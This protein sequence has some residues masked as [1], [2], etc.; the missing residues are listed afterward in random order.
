VAGNARLA[1]EDWAETA[2]H[3]FDVLEVV[4]TVQE[5]VQLFGREAGQRI[6]ELGED[7]GNV[8]T[9][10]TRVPGLV[11]ADRGSL[12]GVTGEAGWIAR[13]SLFGRSEHRQ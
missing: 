11:S 8:G 6:P 12:T 1:I 2:G 7:G 3:I 9:I 13:Q 4:P 10:I 5:E